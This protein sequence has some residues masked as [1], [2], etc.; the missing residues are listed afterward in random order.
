M[1]LID[2]SELKPFLYTFQCFL[3]YEVMLLVYFYIRQYLS[4]MPKPLSS[5]LPADLF[6]FFY[7][8][9]SNQK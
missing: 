7:K 8:I 4:Y 3:Q 9:L 1:V 5:S 2:F 6:R